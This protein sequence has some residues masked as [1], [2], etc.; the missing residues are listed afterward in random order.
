MRVAG[1]MKISC[2]ALAVMAAL[3]GGICLG[4]EKVAVA[5]L[6]EKDKLIVVRAKTCEEMSNLQPVNQTTVF[7]ASRDKAFCFAEIEGIVTTTHIYH[8]WIRRD[9]QVS[10]IKLVVKPPRWSTV[11]SISLRENDKGPWRVEITDMNGDILKI[12]RFSVVD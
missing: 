11:S 3:A 9:Q 12:L 2:I 1:K 4:E 6:K 8:N 7:S 5:G 10:G